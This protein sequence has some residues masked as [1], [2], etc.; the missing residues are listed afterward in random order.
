MMF[1]CT[2]FRTL[3]TW[4]KLTEFACTFHN[5]QASTLQRGPPEQYGLHTLAKGSGHLTLKV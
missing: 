2:D 3:F 4:E 1:H 5:C